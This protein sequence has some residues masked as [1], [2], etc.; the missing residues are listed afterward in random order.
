MVVVR[1]ILEEVGIS[2]PEDRNPRAWP[3]SDLSPT[4]FVL[5]CSQ[6]LSGHSRSLSI[7]ILLNLLS[8]I[9][10]KMHS[11]LK[12][13]APLCSL[14]QNLCAKVRMCVCACVMGAGG[15]SNVSIKGWIQVSQHQ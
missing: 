1:N 8:L 14:C 6:G 5:V 13:I 10:P 12:D 3:C 7:A 11:P 15:M 2:G 4:Q 9:T